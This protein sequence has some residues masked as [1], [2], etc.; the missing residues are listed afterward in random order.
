MLVG[1][2]ASQPQA[3]QPQRV[4]QHGDAESMHI[5]LYSLSMLACCSRRCCTVL[6]CP[7]DNIAHYLQDKTPLCEVCLQR[8]PF[9]HN[10][11]R[12]D[13]R[14]LLSVSVSACS[15]LAAC[16]GVLGAR[17]CRGCL[18]A[19]QPGACGCFDSPQVHDLLTCVELGACL[20]RQQATGLV[21]GPACSCCDSIFD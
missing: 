10:H 11:C 6:L 18:L 7:C 1:R 14:V 17:S 20:T 21:M 3:P 19:T 16:A 12:K 15:V 13:R 4:V 9:A 8:P 5:V 2:Y